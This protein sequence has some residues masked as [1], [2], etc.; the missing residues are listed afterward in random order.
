M[1]S[2]L[3]LFALLFA[4][5]FSVS[6]QAE[7]LR[8]GVV[9][10]IGGLGDESFNDAAYEGI[11]RLRRDE[12]CLVEVIE[13]GNLNGIEPALRY[14]SQRNMDL[15][16]AVGI[17]ANDALRR[18]SNEFPQSRFVLIDSVVTSP[19]VLSILFDEE[20]GSFYAGAFA[21]LV[22]KSGTI[23]FLGGMD[24]P[25]IAGFERGFKNGARFVRPQTKVLANYLGTTPE[26]FDMPEEAFAVGLD[27][28]GKGADVIYHASGKS[29]LGL[30]KASRR[31]N[32]MVVGVDSDQS[33]SA[34]GKVPA[35]MV[36]RI[37]NAMVKASQIMRKGSFNGGIWTMGL[38]DG[39]IELSRS[40]FNRNL[41]DADT[42]AK[43]DE[44]ARFLLHS[45]QN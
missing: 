40:R 14:F 39:G 41:F 45:E 43:L 23:G 44:V 29:G 13:P 17:F 33:R 30:I 31:A 6:A 38:Q 8:I 10:S 1:K 35:S 32:F 2:R 28:A 4:F 20:Q 25:V 42:T 18:V 11:V 37:D 34:P 3:L 16:F 15:I 27:L 9:L 24:S 7:N 19:N 12:K 5:C 21:A 36:K 22:S 26:A